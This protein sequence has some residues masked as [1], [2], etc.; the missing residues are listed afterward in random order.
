MKISC[1]NKI[2]DFILLANEQC[3]SEFVIIRLSCNQNQMK[4]DICDIILYLY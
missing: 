1:T 2:C 4:T 3:K